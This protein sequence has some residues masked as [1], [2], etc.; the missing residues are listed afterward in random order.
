MIQQLATASLNHGH[1]KIGF[2]PAMSDPSQSHL[3]DGSRYA[4]AI[5][6]ALNAL[7][8]MSE[9]R[10]LNFTYVYRDTEFETKATLRAIVEMYNDGVDVLLGPENHC[11][12]SAELAASLSVPM[13]GFVC[14]ELFVRR[15]SCLATRQINIFMRMS[16][17]FI[18]CTTHLLSNKTLYPTFSRTVP[19]NIKVIKSIVAL[20][21]HYNWSCFSI[22]EEETDEWKEVGLTLRAAAEANSFKINT[23]YSFPAKYRL[24]KA[25]HQQVICEIVKKT[26][27]KT[28]VHIFLGEHD[29]MVQFIRC[30]YAH[31]N[32]A[33]HSVIHT[34]SFDSHFDFDSE[35]ALKSL[36]SFWHEGFE[37]FDL[38]P[39]TLAFRQLIT[40]QYRAST[41]NDLYQRFVS[42]VQYALGQPPFFIQAPPSVSLGLHEIET[43]GWERERPVVEIEGWER[44][45]PV[46]ETEGWERERPVVETEGWARERPVVET[47]GWERE[48]PVVE[49]EGWERERPVV[50]TEGWE[51]ERPVVET[52]GWE[53]ER[54]VVETEG[55]EREGPVVE[56]EGWKRERPVVKT[57]GWE[58][59]RPVVE[60]EG[61]ERERPV[62]ETEGWEREGPVVKT[63]GWERERPVVETEGWE[64]ERP[65]VE[66]EGWARERP[67]VETEGWEREGPVVE[68]EG[69]GRERP[70][71]ETEGW[72]RERPVVETEGWARE[73][74]VVEAEGWE[75]EGPVVE[76][77]GW[78]RE[79]PVVETEGWERERPVVETE[80]WARERPVVETEGERPVV[81]TEGWEREKPVVET[82]EWERER[83]VVETEGWERERPVVE[84]EGWER[85]GPVVETEGWA[86]ERPVVETEGWERGR[87]VVETK[88]WE[89]ERPV[90]ETEGWERER[91]VVETE[92]WARE[93]P[94]VETEGLNVNFCQ[95]DIPISRYAAKVYDAVM[96]YAKSVKALI[97]LGGDPRNAQE[98]TQMVIN[99]S[100]T[101]IQQFT[102]TIDANG[103]AEGA[104][105]T[106]AMVKDETAPSGWSVY[107]TG[108]FDKNGDSFISLTYKPTEQMSWLSGK[109]P[110][111]EPA[112]GFEG[113]TSTLSEILVSSLMSG[114]LLLAILVGLWYWR[115]RVQQKKIDSL[116][117]KLDKSD[118]EIISSRLDLDDYT[119]AEQDSSC[120]QDRPWSFLDGED[121]E[122][123]ELP[124]YCPVGYFKNML[125]SLKC[126]WKSLELTKTAKKQ[127]HELKELS[128]ENINKFIGA[129]I[130]PPHTFIVFNYCERGSLQNV[131]LANRE[132]FLTTSVMQYS[133]I[134]DLVKGLMFIHS[135]FLTCHGNLKSSK[136]LVDS[137]FVLRISGFGWHYFKKNN[138]LPEVQSTKD[139]HDRLWRAP[140]LLRLDAAGRGDAGTWGSQKG[141]IYSFG[142]IVHEILCLQGPWGETRLSDREIVEGVTNG[143]LPLIRPN[144]S[145]CKCDDYLKGCMAESWAEVPEVRPDV[146]TLRHKIKPLRLAVGSNIM[147]S[148][149]ERIEMYTKNLEG[150][151][152]ARTQ[153][154]HVE[155]RRTEKL[156]HRMLPRSVAEDLK[157][158]KQVEASYH[159]CVTICFSDIVGFTKLCSESDPYQIVRFLNDL[160]TRFDE[161]IDNYDVYKVETI[162]DAY[163]VV[164]G[165]PKPNG[166]NHAGEIA[167]MALHLVRALTNFKIEHRPS[168]RLQLRLGIH[169]GP[170]AVGVVG[171]KM[172]RYCLF[173]DTVNTTSRME[174]HGL[175]LKVHCSQQCK[176]IL[177]RLGG[178]HLKERGIIEMKGKG[179]VITYW[180]TG[181]DSFHRIQR[182]AASMQPDSPC[183]STRSSFEDNLH[184]MPNGFQ[185]LK[186]VQ[187]QMAINDSP[188]KTHVSTPTSRRNIRRGSMPAYDLKLGLF[189]LTKRRGSTPHNGRKGLMRSEGVVGGTSVLDTV[190][191]LKAVR[192]GPDGCE[193]EPEI[194]SRRP[195][196][197]ETEQKRMTAGSPVAMTVMSGLT[198]GLT[199]CQQPT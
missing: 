85:E 69:W 136:C 140:E 170:V 112:C 199:S 72:A 146:K 133:L 109:V 196:K 17:L 30:L 96:L 153:Q 100:Y 76:T 151:V 175:P 179:Q 191:P 40:L 189:E 52:E 1:F 142:I 84:T 83:P 87:P 102:D 183:N 143:N 58:R 139:Y 14:V 34:R 10:G 159:E 104:Y 63:E 145:A 137:R 147:E 190:D 129:C 77:E 182:L 105:S 80:G 103:D 90:V 21:K 185:R 167:S 47:E 13:I 60:T 186:A 8:N 51:R 59:E 74:P 152:E 141:D 130:D 98:L 57:E 121:E 28:R 67:V 37:P 166:D 192:A 180:L 107:Q 54:P 42:D 113:C 124:F 95:V 55:W 161:I 135:S 150:Q 157:K 44:K 162:G 160:Y 26:M 106:V 27:D 71:V 127:L 128:H 173:G 108:K 99:T 138:S 50:K 114:L 7:R 131:L 118:I 169:S 154:L 198:S 38:N 168:D 155:K 79:R 24:Y 158:G 16:Y 22:V 3:N 53:R 32:I 176:A 164:S 178:Y 171:F 177:D 197:R 66:T 193:N 91:P 117:W 20:L 88:G 81:E 15:N 187:N 194:D 56:T 43:E 82:E 39:Q 45:R 33:L 64:R 12:I 11:V 111:D 165:L 62:V 31:S 4:G 148:M 172:P 18:R 115:R 122:P 94:V 48:G 23:N 195:S 65:V 149:L 123:P 9:Y 181:D 86:R 119:D 5:S 188:F 29:G 93:R 120:E 49:T 70:V 68:T 2:L 184:L 25:E 134:N 156:L 19:S 73:R 75:R 78:K 36:T 92:G 97:K 89:R 110:K 125:V 116:L 174:S 6:V 144:L 132:L 35:N 163:M 41:D 46:V 101:S 126:E 61:W